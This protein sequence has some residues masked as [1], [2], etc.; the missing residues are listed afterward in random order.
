MDLED[1]LPL[2]VIK[3]KVYVGPIYRL[4]STLSKGIS[5][6]GNSRGVPITS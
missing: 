2:P 6:S 3:R 4:P 1:G 5:H